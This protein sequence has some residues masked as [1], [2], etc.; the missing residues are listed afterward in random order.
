MA[1]FCFKIN[2]YQIF[3]SKKVLQ[4][5]GNN[6]YYYIMLNFIVNVASGNG[7]AKKAIHKVA[8]FL[9]EKKINFKVFYS[10]YKGHLQHIATELEKAGETDFV[11]VGGDGS[12]N[13]VLNGFK[14]PSKINLGLIPA[15]SGNDFAKAAGISLKPLQAINDILQ[16]NIEPIDYLETHEK[17]AINTI[18]I[19][20][21]ISVIKRYNRAEKKTKS[22]YHIALIK[23]LLFFRGTKMQFDID[24]SE[25]QE[26]DY[27]VA[28][29]SNGRFFGGGMKVSPHSKI[30][31]GKINFVAI[32]RIPF[33]KVFG[34]MNSMKKG[35][36]I[37]GKYTEEY[38]CD[39]VVSNTLM[40][41]N[42]QTINYDGEL[43]E[44]SVFD[45]TCVENGINFY[46]P[47]R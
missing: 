19:G 29:A 31:D 8:D 1:M 15:G 3:L 33:L 26:D 23:S 2:Q 36:H 44:N 27:M 5:N 22:A 14:N 30:N 9:A 7:K 39:R 17:R 12:I 45:V 43:L 37:E 35:K 41:G 38:L 21:D 47:K 40:E 18:S 24:G 25:K 11:V 34:V 46:L 6:I 32:K 16:N 20:I 4:I 42:M 28:V 10:H 13:E